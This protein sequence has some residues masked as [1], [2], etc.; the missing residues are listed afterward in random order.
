MTHPN[1]DLEV[2]LLQQNYRIIAGAD[3]AG[4]GSLFGPVCVGIAVLPLDDLPPLGEILA[5]VRDSKQLPRPKVYE[6]AEVVKAVCVAWEVGEA[7]AQEIDHYGIVGGVELAFHRAFAAL[8]VAV[9]YVLADHNMPLR[10]L[11]LPY[12]TY[13]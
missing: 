13:V 2:A 9:E 6:L 11:T 3:E 5:E 4:R 10:K 8:G 12:Q 7:S 1:F